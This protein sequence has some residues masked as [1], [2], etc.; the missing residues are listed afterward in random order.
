MKIADAAFGHQ[1]GGFVRQSVAT[2]S[3]SRIGVLARVVHDRAPLMNL[4]R[5]YNSRMTA[6]RM[7]HVFTDKGNHT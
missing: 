3:G 4:V 6:W 1:P 7:R 2:L 5:L